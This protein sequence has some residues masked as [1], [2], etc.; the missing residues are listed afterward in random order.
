ML[1]KIHAKTNKMAFVFLLSTIILM[2]WLHGGER[3]W[4]H[5]IFISISFFIAALILIAYFFSEENISKAIT[6]IKIPLIL[7]TLWFSYLLIQVVPLPLKLLAILPTSTLT[8]VLKG[9]NESY[10]HTISV[11]VELSKITLIKYVGYIIFFV[12]TYLTLQN[13][14]RAIILA[15][16][17][18]LAS[19]LMAIYSMLNYLSNG[20]FLINDSLMPYGNDDWT[21]KVRGAFSYP[22]NYTSFLILTI[23]IGFGLLYYNISKTFSER[24]ISYRF[25]K[26][27]SLLLLK[28]YY[29][30]ICLVFMLAAILNTASRGGN[31]AFIIAISITLLSVYIK[32]KNLIIPFKKHTRIMLISFL[33]ITLVLMVSGVANN[34]LERYLTDGMQF[35]GRNFSNQTSWAMFSDNFLFGTGIGTY[36]AASPYYK[37]F[38]YGVSVRS[39]NAHALNDY[40]ELLAEQGI[41]GFLIF[42]A[43]ISYLIYQLF[44]GLKYTKNKLWGLQIA[45]YCSCIG[46]LIHSLIDFNFQLPVNTIFFYITLA[47]GIK[48][49]IFRKL[50]ITISSARYDR[51]K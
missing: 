36:S 43:T 21:K 35:H 1:N 12:L 29:Y 42:G 27:F 14:K 30:I 6:N 4:E 9:I 40:M 48:I 28:H 15:N 32:N 22:A 49:S 8:Q 25:N 11:S 17:L 24:A 18:F 34:L 7:F 44:L 33:F 45:S 41:I 50:N 31:I 10:Y 39:I 16:T 51:I 3:I 19:A 38:E 26:L 5:F 2:P 23:P 13:T 46:I 47:L 20:S 37:V